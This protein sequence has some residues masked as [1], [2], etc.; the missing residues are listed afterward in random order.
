MKYVHRPEVHPDIA[1]QSKR[2][3]DSVNAYMDDLSGTVVAIQRIRSGQAGPYQDTIDEAVIFCY[4]PNLFTTNG[5]G[6]YGITL[7]EAKTLARIF[8]GNW[9]DNPQFLESRLEFLRP[10]MNPCGLE[11]TKIA[12]VTGRSMCW[13]VRIRK[14]YCD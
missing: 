8:V 12:H 5:P 3:I 10:E 1:E 4:R 11:Q 14:P 9:S 13:R 2:E 6:A 7:E